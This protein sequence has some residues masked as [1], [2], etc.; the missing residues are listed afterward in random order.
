MYAVFE[1]TLLTDQGK[2]LVRD[3]QCKYNAQTIYRELCAYAFISTKA[4]MD[5]SSM[6]CYITTTQLGDGS[7]KGTMHAF[8]LHWKDQVCKYHDLAPN[9]QLPQ[10]LQHTML[11]NAV[12][13]IEAL[14]QVKSQAEQQQTQTN[15]LLTY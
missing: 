6:L 11:E 1:K 14:K 3:H 10:D 13:P 12:H 4:T 15:T 8:I 2:T 5:A 9:Q 7:W